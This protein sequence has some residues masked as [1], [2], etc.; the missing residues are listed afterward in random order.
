MSCLLTHSMQQ[1]TH[2]VSLLLLL[3]ATPGRTTFGG[4]DVAQKYKVHQNAPFKKNQ[5]FSPQRGPTR[6]F[7]KLCV[8]VARVP[9]WLSTGLCATSIA[10]LMY[11]HSHSRKK[12]LKNKN[13]KKTLGVTT[14]ATLS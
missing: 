10:S 3:E 13:T 7:R 1:T 11:V 12:E 6:M 9:M 8:N 4:P 14:Y 5:K 2:T